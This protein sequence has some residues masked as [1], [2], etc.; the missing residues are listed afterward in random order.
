MHA[1]ADISSTVRIARFDELTPH[2]LHDILRLR[3]EVFVVE[4]ACVFL[5]IDGRDPEPDTRH[6]WLRDEAGALAATARLLHDDGDTW[7]IGRVVTRPDLRSTGIAAR[8]LTEAISEAGALGATAIDL[9]AQS[10]LAPWYARF[11]FE[12]CGAEYVEDDIPHLPMRRLAPAA[13]P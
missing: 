10:H 5:E 2:D 3:S 8:L 12:V 7:S 4:Q 6:L 9:G 11:G 1:V 13:A